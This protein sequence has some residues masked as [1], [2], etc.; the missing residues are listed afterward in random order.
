MSGPKIFH[1]VTREEI[2]AICEGHLARL[3]A[4]IVEWK[5]VGERNHTVTP[6][7]I[8]AVEARRD[9]LRRLLTEERFI[10]LQ[11]Q[12]PAEIL[13]VQI[14][15][16]S[17]LQWAAAAAVES[18]RAQRRAARTAEMLLDELN[19]AGRTL[20]DELHRALVMKTGAAGEIEAAINKAFALLSAGTKPSGVTDRQRAIAEQHGRDEQRMTLADWIAVQ[21]SVRDDGITPQLDQHLVELSALGDDVARFEARASAI[22]KEPSS[23]RR[24]LL[25]DSLLIE[26]GTAV[27]KSRERAG[28]LSNLRERNAELSRLK[29]TTAQALRAEIDNA[30][31]SED[32]AAAPDLLHHANA[33]I[34][35]EIQTMAAAARRRAVLQGLA[36]L[37]YEVTEGMATAWVE[38]GRLVLRKAANPDYGVELG[39]GSQSSRLQVR[40]VG[41]GNSQATRDPSRDR[42]MEAIWCGEFERLQA[43]IAQAGGDIKLEK[44]LAVGAVPIKVIQDLKVQDTSP[45]EV[46]ELRRMQR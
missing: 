14:D 20:P 9:A 29:T 25:S 45:I 23:S 2:I 43:L 35:E 27:K 42:D 13:F 15:A 31:S 38:N 40:A 41:F 37:G 34:G 19:K 26:L 33:L 32:T 16:Q 8:S 44:A 46:S 11:K 3:D 5:R 30:L 17:R 10:E 6:T 24:A 18:R 22:A 4:A 7:D 12:V 21:P 36:S 39:G 28:L 1:I